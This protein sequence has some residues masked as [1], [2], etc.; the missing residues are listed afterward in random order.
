MLSKTR[1]AASVLGSLAGLFLLDAAVFRSNLYPSVLEPYSSTG[2]FETT[3][4]REKLAQRRYGDNLVAIMGDSRV[5]FLPRVANGGFTF[6]TGYVFRL[7]GVAGTD[8]RSQFYMLRDLDPQANRYRAIAI[9]VTDIDDSEI[10]LPD[11]AEDD[12]ALHYIIKRLRLSDVWGF[13]RSFHSPALQW[14]AF[15]GGLLK[16]SVYQADIQDFIVDP[17]KR[18]AFVRKVHEGYESWSYDYVPPAESLAGLQIDWIKGSVVVPDNFTPA[19]RAA[20]DYVVNHKPLVHQRLSEFR[21]LWFGRIA[22]HYRGSKTKVILFRVAR[23][24]F[25]FPDRWYVS[26]G[27]SIRDLAARQSNV[28]ILNEH[29]FEYLERPDM[30]GD[31]MHLNRAGADSFS[32]KLAQ[33]V[34]K[35]LGPANAL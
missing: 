18:I 20:V 16:G 14:E 35:I 8:P 33:E 31:G 13:A 15:R 12:R 24:P 17:C 29:T 19:Q 21:R 26:S 25:P 4:R 27:T 32:T 1:I 2:L 30:F 10:D 11:R 34:A 3:L 28:L 6:P 22:D 9:G 5:A 7:A 23:S